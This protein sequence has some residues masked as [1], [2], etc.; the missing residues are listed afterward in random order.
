MTIKLEKIIDDETPE[1]RYRIKRSMF[2]S[3]IL[4][5]QELKNLLKLILHYLGDE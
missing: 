3:M 4:T 1:I 2:N 5:E